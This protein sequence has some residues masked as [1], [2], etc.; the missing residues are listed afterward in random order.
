MDNFTP[1]PTTAIPQKS[2]KKLIIGVVAALLVSA[3]LAGYFIFVPRG[4]EIVQ[5]ALKIEQAHAAT[6]RAQGMLSSVNE[7]LG[8]ENF[9]NLS[10]Q[11]RAEVIAGLDSDKKA[12]LAQVLGELQTAMNEAA[13]LTQEAIAENEPGASGGLVSD[14]SAQ[15]NAQDSAT[16]GSGGTSESSGSASPAAPTSV[17]DGQADE[18]A[19]SATTGSGAAETAGT[20][21]STVEDSAS[22]ANSGLQEVAGLVDTLSSLQEAASQTLNSI[23]EVAPEGSALDAAASQALQESEQRQALI[24]EMIQELTQALVDESGL[25]QEKAA[26]ILQELTEHMGTAL[27]HAS[28]Q[29]LEGL[30]NA[31]EAQTKRLIKPEET[32][33]GGAQSETGKGN[34]NTPAT[35][36]HPQPE[37]QTQ[38]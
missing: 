30:Q 18:S 2:R 27:E 1:A 7:L 31:I 12:E 10:A 38:Q 28:E 19:T 3:A 35:P 26:A 21:G 9:E 34:Q 33:T 5:E 22:T 24:D 6:S 17:A 29:G 25:S 20:A 37:M 36:D 13:R 8:V 32:G 11:E 4:A 23:A 14:G 16:A 15:A